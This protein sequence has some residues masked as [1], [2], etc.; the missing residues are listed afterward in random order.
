MSERSDR[1]QRSAMGSVLQADSSVYSTKHGYD[2]YLASARQRGHLEI[3]EN[4]TVPRL[5]VIDSTSPKSS[6]SLNGAL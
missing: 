4:T 6:T 5:P 1:V 3:L 2:S